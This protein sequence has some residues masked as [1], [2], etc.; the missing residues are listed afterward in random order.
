MV[1]SWHGIPPSLSP[2]AGAN[3][4]GTMRR[5][6]RHRSGQQARRREERHRGA[7]IAG[8]V[9]EGIVGSRDK[10]GAAR[11]GQRGAS[12]L[13]LPLVAENHL[14]CPYNSREEGSYAVLASECVRPLSL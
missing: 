14:D 4:S 13:C 3:G 12:G 1:S 7:P 8:A 11:L 5:G 6:T 2:E 9:W 10:A